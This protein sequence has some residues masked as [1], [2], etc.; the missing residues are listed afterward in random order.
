MYETHRQAQQSM[1][2]RSE[3]RKLLIIPANHRVIQ[4]KAD[5]K[6]RESQKPPLQRLCLSSFTVK[7]RQMKRGLKLRTDF[8]I[9]KFLCPPTV[10]RFF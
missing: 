6:R 7:K 10:S 5:K 9:I 2:R 3:F 1:A 4:E 8:G